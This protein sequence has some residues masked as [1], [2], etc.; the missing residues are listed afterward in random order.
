MAKLVIEGGQAL[1][2][3]IH[4]A[5]AKNSSFKLMIASLLAQGETKLNNISHI[6]EV[7]NVG[8]MITALGGR[9]KPIAKRGL[10]I[11]TSGIKSWIIPQK[12][13]QV[14]RASSLFLGPLLARFG[15]AVV[16]LPGGD[17]IGRRPLDRHL[18]A[19]TKL[20]AKIKTS[21]NL[22]EASAAKLAGITYSFAKASHTAT[23]NLLM[24]AVLAKGKTVIATAAREPEVDDLI[25]F[26]NQM[27]GRIV[28][29]GKNI[30]IT[31]VPE[32]HPV[33]FNVMPDRNQAVSYAVA[34]LCTKGEVTITNARPEHL[35]AFLN[36]LKQAG[37]GTEVSSS[38]IRFFYRQELKAADITTQPHPGF[39]TD[40]QPLW[41][42]LATQSTG[43]S[44]I[45]EAVFTHRFQV[46]PDLV[47]MGAKINWFDPRPKNPESFYNF[48]LA[49]D[50]PQ[51]HHG[52][53]VAGPARLRGGEFAVKD[54]RNGATLVIAGLMA[55][56]RTVLNQAELIDRGYEDF[57]GQ[58]SALGA[59]IE[60]IN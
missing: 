49:D 25:N 15:K 32:L 60:R 22:L 42:V 43:T 46:V 55:S 38:G 54:I 18:D 17:A 33:E 6:S 14:S 31:G 29:R 45:I 4:L 52:I 10:I 12:L 8:Q 20:G 41:T 23:E 34:A 7:D 39:M 58:L 1:K 26:L 40:W 56:G 59:K 27:G 5:G 57:A 44:K 13:G 9:V 37:A 21:R 3:T 50:E 35:A 48:N 51:N 47:K 30:E 53:I 11:D 28:R 19:L 24:A 2:G 16:P 36:K